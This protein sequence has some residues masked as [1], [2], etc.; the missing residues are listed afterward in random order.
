M[1][2]LLPANVNVCPYYRETDMECICD[3]ED[4]SCS[5]RQRESVTQNKKQ[6]E[7]QERWYEQ[8]YK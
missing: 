5:Y 4:I 6:Y 3:L 2:C 7:R 1:K 8:Y